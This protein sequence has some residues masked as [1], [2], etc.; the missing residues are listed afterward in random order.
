MASAASEC[1]WQTTI[2]E[3]N[4]DPSDTR[5]K[6]L[7]ASLMAFTLLASPTAQAA[8]LAIGRLE[9]NTNHCRFGA[10]SAQDLS[11]HR[12]EL[13][14]KTDNV[15]R[16]RFIGES[17]QQGRGRSLTFVAINPDQPLPLSCERGQCTLTAVRWQGAV[18][19]VAEA[20]TTTLGIAEGLP[21][22]WPAQGS[23]KLVER[24]FS[25]TAEVITGKVFS[26]EG[27][28]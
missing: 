25:C 1:V 2:T 11:C 15:L 17:E 28:L 10:P 6:V 13:A 23:C 7:G 24:R 19:G 21:K 16:L 12:I 14:R 5:A 27:R 20:L 4:S 3:Q 8:A 9:V 18:V 22:A 26:A